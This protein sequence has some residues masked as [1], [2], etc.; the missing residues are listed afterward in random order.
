MILETPWLGWM[1]DPTYDNVRDWKYVPA[2]VMVDNV[3]LNYL[4]PPILDQGSNGSCVWQAIAGLVY[5]EHK[6]QGHSG[7]LLSRMRGWWQA[8]K[9][10]GLD[11]YN[12]G[13][14]LRQSFGILN[15]TG[16]CAESHFPHTQHVYDQ[17]PPKDADRMAIDQSAKYSKRAG[18]K[19]VEYQRLVCPKGPDRVLLFR[20]ALAAGYQIAFGID[21]DETFVS[22]DFDHSKPYNLD[23]SPIRGGHAMRIVASR[24]DGFLVANS[25]G[26]NWGDNG[27]FL[28][29]HALAGQARDPWIVV[30]APYYSELSSGRPSRLLRPATEPP[31][32]PYNDAATCESVCAHWATLKCPEAAPSPAGVSCVRVCGANL[33]WSLPCLEAVESCDQ[34]DLCPS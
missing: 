33:G 20:E 6:K 9:E 32:G 4:S 2:S 5:A 17:Q 23:A 29:G 28:M 18:R 3:D 31:P 34:I 19:P 12:V 11:E 22:N 27:H 1:P 21:V 15:R 26:E 24:S 8:R 10:Q 30:T 25:W 14:W 7:P 16:Y 13:C